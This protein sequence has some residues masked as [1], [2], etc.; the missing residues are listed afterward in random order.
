MNKSL[1]SKIF[2]WSQFVLNTIGQ[3]TTSGGVPHG[4]VDGNNAG[5]VRDS[6]RYSW[7]IEHGRKQGN[8]STNQKA[9]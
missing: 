9:G 2:G 7:R 8:F 1:F 3:V 5:I 4:W 6:G